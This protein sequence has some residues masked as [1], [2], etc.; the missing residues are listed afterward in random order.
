MRPTVIAMRS[1]TDGTASG[2]L[3]WRYEMLT[4]TPPAQ[5]KALVYVADS[6]FEQLSN[7]AQTSS[8]PGSDLLRQ[9]IDR[10][11]V[12]AEEE[13]PKVFVRLNSAVE[14]TDMLTGR[15][16]KLTLVLT[17][18]AEIHQNPLYGV[19]PTGRSYKT[20]MRVRV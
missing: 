18:T 1:T 15:T 2:G 19:P 14:Y 10:A 6:Q 20:E 7:L 12:L 4:T 5:S 3:P 17:Q 11:I 13:S 9:E 8:A 16:R